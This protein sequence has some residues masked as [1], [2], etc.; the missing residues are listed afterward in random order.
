MAL[1]LAEKGFSI[2]DHLSSRSVF[3]LKRSQVAGSLS[4]FALGFCMLLV[5]GSSSGIIGFAVTTLLTAAFFLFGYKGRTPGAIVAGAVSHL[6]E[7]LSEF[8]SGYGYDAFGD[9]VEHSARTYVVSKS[10]FGPMRIWESRT[11]S[12]SSSR[13]RRAGGEIRKLT[14]LKLDDGSLLGVAREH[15]GQGS[16]LGFEVFGGSFAFLDRYEKL[17]RAS[18][19]G[20]AMGSLAGLAGK[21]GSLV[22]L[23]SVGR[24][25]EGFSGCK[26]PVSGELEA[27]V[28]EISSRRIAR[29]SFLLVRTN[30]GRK[31][32]EIVSEVM[33]LIYGLG[34]SCKALDGESLS[35]LFAFGS[36]GRNEKSIQHVRARWSHLQIDEKLMRLFDVSELPTGEVDPDFLVPFLTSLTS[37]SVLGF[38]LK[39]IDSR[40]AIRKVRS[41]RSGVTAD[42]GVR[43]LF[44][45]LARNSEARAISSLEVQENDLDLGYEMLAVSGRF[46]VVAESEEELKTVSSQAVAKAEQ[47]GISLECGYGRQ[48]QLRRRLFG[49]KG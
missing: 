18:A 22:I 44:G 3:G 4:G 28:E 15:R 11:R 25:G 19:L 2:G 45:F 1:G 29:R 34:L 30:G 27:L 6:G 37:E 13:S 16:V 9:P 41:R 23:Y 42:A 12:S 39:A 47:V 40:F 33:P 20:S 21:V 49:A 17:E 38:Q 5:F 35:A 48:L 14:E 8:G 36:A 7:Q 32:G 46:A 24:Q 31:D 43:A 26:E 10:G